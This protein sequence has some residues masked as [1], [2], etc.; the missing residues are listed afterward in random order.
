MYVLPTTSIRKE[1]DLPPKGD[2]GENPLLLRLYRRPWPKAVV[3]LRA[4]VT[5]PW[6]VYTSITR[7]V[8][9]R[10]ESERPRM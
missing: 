5:F 2:M 4:S 7:R 1:V 3:K 8:S 9:L 10:M 6:E